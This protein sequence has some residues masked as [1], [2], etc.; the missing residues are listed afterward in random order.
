MPLVSI[1]RRCSCAHQAT[2]SPIWL[3][4]AK[5]PFA[6]C[7]STNI[8]SQFAIR[9]KLAIIQ[10]DAGTRV[11]AGRCSLRRSLNAMCGCS[12]DANRKTCPTWRSCTRTSG[13]ASLYL[14]LPIALFIKCQIIAVHLVFIRSHANGAAAL[15]KAA[16]T[17]ELATCA[18]ERDVYA[19]VQ[20][21]LRQ[22]RDAR[23]GATML[24]V[25]S[26]V[27]LR[28]LQQHVPMCAEFPCVP[29]PI[30]AER[31]AT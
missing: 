24:C 25:H 15:P 16:H 2:V 18:S 11:H 20:R 29:V 9:I 7:T 4:T 1:C 28:M 14:P 12:I 3:K 23:H 22:Y 31:L 5:L 26:A 6:I 21:Q 10:C 30:P 19:G 27:P 13:S 17:F 8:H